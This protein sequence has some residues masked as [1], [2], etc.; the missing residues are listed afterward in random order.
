MTQRAATLSEDNG[1]EKRKDNNKATA[2]VITKATATAKPSENKKGRRLRQSRRATVRERQSRLPN[3]T[4]GAPR[5]K[6]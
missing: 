2:T 4:N 5:I 1:C 3:S 6:S